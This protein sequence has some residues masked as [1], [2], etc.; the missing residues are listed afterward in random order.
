MSELKIGALAREITDKLTP[1]YGQGEA[2]AMTR[3]IF[4]TLKGW[5]QTQL[6]INSDQPASEYIVRKTSDI[7]VRLLTNEPIQYILGE[8]YFY[9]MVLKVDKSTLIP[10]P[11]T[12]QLVDLIYDRYKEQSD[13]SI[14]DIGTG[15]GA[16]A[17]A[18]ARHLPYA[19]ISAIDISAEA[20]KVAKANADSLSLKVDFRICDV[21]SFDPTPDSFDIIVS[22]PP[23]VDESEKSEMQPNVLNYEPHTALFVPDSNPLL[24]YR[25]IS[26]IG[27]KALKPGGSLFFEINPRHSEE[28]EQMLATLGYTDIDI[29]KDIHQR[30]RFVIATK[31]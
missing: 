1:I 28:M 19:K 9:G 25:K 5:N 29:I 15:S 18:L 7:L 22:N 27:L 21:F 16:I 26:E 17:L 11:E 12:E 8:A 13:L 14:L 4:Q 24:F 20:I 6:I 31:Q 3:L 10:R 30:N 2:K 23:Y